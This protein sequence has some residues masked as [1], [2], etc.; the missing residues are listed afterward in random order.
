MNDYIE[1]IKEII[2]KEAYLGTVRR[3]GSLYVVYDDRAF[4]LNDIKE[5]LRRY[6]VPQ[7]LNTPSFAGRAANR[8]NVHKDIEDMDLGYL[9][10]RVRRRGSDGMVVRDDHYSNG[11]VTSKPV[12]HIARTLF[13]TE[14][15][16][17]SDKLT[18]LYLDTADELFITV[19]GRTKR[20]DKRYHVN[21]RIMMYYDHIKDDGEITD[22]EYN[23]I[24]ELIESEGTLV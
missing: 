15:H 5:E 6:M 1:E 7:W 16:W 10:K 21:K 8:T 20:Q 13:L 23:H 2:G 19:V 24:L 12:A 3:S 14:Y 18:D 22:D 9:V 11:V 17:N 4:N